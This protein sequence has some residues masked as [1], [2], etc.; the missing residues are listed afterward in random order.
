MAA[1]QL[2]NCDTALLASAAEIPDLYEE[3]ESLVR[4]VMDALQQLREQ[5][6]LTPDILHEM[7]CQAHKLKS[8]ICMVGASR[9]AS[10]CHH[11]GHYFFFLNLHVC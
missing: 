7:G 9:L 8:G 5:G 10:L 11:L 4:Q 1:L 6:E 2:L 3:S